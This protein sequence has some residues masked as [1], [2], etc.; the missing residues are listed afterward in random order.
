M[1][2]SFLERL[3]EPQPDPGGGAAAAYGGSLG[4]ALLEK[5]VRLE[6]AR[7]RGAGESVNHW[8]Q[9]LQEIP[10]LSGDFSRLMESDVVAYKA[11]V[12]A[13]CS[14]DANQLRE[15]VE[16][17][18]HCPEKIMLTARRALQLACKVAESCKH[19]LVADLLVAVGFLGAAL[20]G[21]HHIALANLP[22]IKGIGHRQM[23][24]SELSQ[25][26]ES[27]CQ[28]EDQA[29]GELLG[30]LHCRLNS[31]CHGKCRG[32]RHDP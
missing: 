32:E 30:R 10:E 18:I 31:E 1:N 22:L 12:E 7:N 5:I 3:A 4:L 26:L 25:V 27:A 21:G 6:H 29:T 13:R 20:R 24:Q 17:A 14:G 2:K 19:H 16:N 23:R 28:L 9:M 15:A 11:L 8:R